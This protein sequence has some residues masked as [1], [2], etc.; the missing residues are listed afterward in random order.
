VHLRHSGLT[1][2]YL[3]AAE[4]HDGRDRA[5]SQII[6]NHL[7]GVLFLVPDSDGRAVRSEI[8]TND[9]HF[10]DLGAKVREVRLQQQRQQGDGTAC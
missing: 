1:S 9:A 5:G 7:Y 10:Q 8:N 3:I 2:Y 6:S 4:C